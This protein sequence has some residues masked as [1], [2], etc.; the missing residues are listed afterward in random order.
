M[1]L[2]L[3]TKLTLV[4]TSLVLLVVA[5]LCGVFLEQLLQQ[6]LHDADR[7]ANELA[8][9]A[10]EDVSHALENAKNQGLRP[11]SYEPWEIHDYVQR[12]FAMNEKLPVELKDIAQSFAIYEV[13]I[14]DH[15]GF[16]LASSDKS[17]PGSL[18]LRRAPFSQLVQS[19]F[20]KQIKI[21]AGPSRLY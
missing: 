19:P 7:S 9:Q 18:S 15:D 12:A 10:F 1:Q 11:G 16:V 17:L 14:V 21:L 4:M 3:R 5:V 13:S 6:V 2:R 20:I 8:G